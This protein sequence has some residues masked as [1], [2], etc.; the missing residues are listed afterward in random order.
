MLWRKHAQRLLVDGNKTS[1]VPRLIEMVNDQDV[2]ELGLNV[3]AIHAMWTL[4]GLGE[5]GGEN[6]EVL[7]AVVGALEHP[8][9]GVRKNAVQVLPT[10]RSGLQA[11]LDSELLED[12]DPKV[13]RGALI[14]LS[15]MPSN[16]TAG[17]ATYEILSSS[18]NLS[19]RW[20]REAG[21]LAAS[22]HSVG[23]LDAA[24]EAGTLS[25]AESDNSEVD[26][27]STLNSIIKLVLE[28]SP[29]FQADGNQNPTEN[30]PEN[31]D[32][33]LELGVIPNVLEFD[34][35]ELRVKAGETVRVTFTNTGNM[36]HNLLFINPGT[37]Q[38]IGA[39][40]DKMITSS[41]G[42]D[43]N[44]VPETPDVIASTEIIQPGESVQI[45][46][47]VPS[48]PGEYQFVCTIPGHWR[49]M[50]GTLIVEP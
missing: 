25:G 21:A 46:F 40:A 19:D 18:E 31:V 27:A 49:S 23:F 33:E 24:S 41:E 26:P 44:Y 29:N 37:I 7:A 43:K 45:T 32:A 17:E 3:G 8:S 47:E 10:T 11:I 42:R 16:E 38:E 48:E 39:M 13:R 2:D 15:E 20:L 50:Q 9:A 22:V 35:D 30:I 6:D 1:A 4:H 14:A 36:E 5:L 34:K 28:E 12:E